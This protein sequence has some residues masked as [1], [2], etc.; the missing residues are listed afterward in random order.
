M[1]IGTAQMATLDALAFEGAT[2]RSKPNLKVSPHF[3]YNPMLRKQANSRIR[4]VRLSTLEYH[5][6]IEIWNLRLN[7][8]TQRRANQM[9]LVSLGEVQ[10][11]IVHYRHVDS[12]FPNCTSQAK[13]TNARLLN[14]K[15][16]LL[17]SLAGHF[18]FEMAV[19]LNGR[20]W[21][22]AGTVGQTIALKRV[23]EGYDAGEIG[24]GKGE[25]DRA[26]KGVL[27]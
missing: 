9:V 20:I 24:L 26:V 6:P 7:V 3:P 18:P 8:S 11:S 15:F 27:A 16:Q 12:T 22:K 25:I 17:T 19:G 5:L 10:R 23:L 4:S 2:K 13:L 1:D 21:F 14:P